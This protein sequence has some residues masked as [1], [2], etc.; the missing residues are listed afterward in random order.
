MKHYPTLR[1]LQYFQ[2]LYET[3]HFGDAAQQC[4]ISQPTLSNAI[5]ELETTLGVSL[6][7]RRRKKLVR[8]THVADDIYQAS[9]RVFP[10]MDRIMRISQS[11]EKPFSGPMRI[12]IIPTIA[13]YLIPRILPALQ[14]TFPL[15]DFQLTEKMSGNLVEKLETDQI[16]L[17]VMAFPFDIGTAQQSF[18]MEEPFYCAAPQGTFPSNTITLD[19]LEDK[20]LLL[21]EDGHCLREHALAACRLQNL[22]EKKS[23]SATS[24]LTLM[25]MVAQG[26]GITLIPEMAVKQGVVPDNVSLH[27]FQGRQPTRKIGLAW[28]DDALQE[29]NINGV[30]SIL[31]ELFTANVAAAA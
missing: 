8:F 1:Q 5:K 18:L 7:D 25:Q 6:M 4:H 21:L 26:Y 20:K 9:R 23:L 27:E 19:D 31:E 13:P 14:K 17:A 22:Q 15:M 24:L 3:K 12:G 2:A 30:R 11:L 16:D 29:T 10:E 28:R